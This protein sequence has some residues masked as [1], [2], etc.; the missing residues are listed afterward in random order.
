MSGPVRRVIIVPERKEITMRAAK[1][2]GRQAADRPTRTRVG[3]SFLTG[4]AV[5]V[6]LAYLLDTERG[7]RR[8]RLIVDR[9]AASARRCSRHCVRATRN[10]VARTEGHGKGFLHRLQPRGKE[11]PDDVTLA[12]RV[13]SI[14][15]RDHRFPKGRISINA[16]QSRVF[17]RGE[18][19]RPELI[20]DLAEAVRR[21]PGVQGVENLLHLPGTPPPAR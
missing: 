1:L 17:L 2:A 3:R 14:V 20:E 19:D 7:H 18:L 4:V 15:F 5:G 16:E 12:H 9:T 21:V 8:R 10:A 11:P 6:A 13:E